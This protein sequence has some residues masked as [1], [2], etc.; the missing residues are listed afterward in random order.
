MIIS[1]VCSFEDV[2]YGMYY[3]SVS[4]AIASEYICD[5]YANALDNFSSKTTLYEDMILRLSGTY[6]RHPFD[7]VELQ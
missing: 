3:T 7:A 5:M 1:Q 2:A 4:I 6:T